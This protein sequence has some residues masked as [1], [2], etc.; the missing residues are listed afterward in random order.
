MKDI[1]KRLSQ[2]NIGKSLAGVAIALLSLSAGA[3]STNPGTYN[4]IVIEDE[5]F[6]GV[7]Q[8]GQHEQAINGLTKRGAVNSRNFTVNNNLCVAYL[9]SGKFNDAKGYC[10]QA[11]A[12]QLKGF[13][14][15]YGVYSRYQDKAIAYTNRGVFRALTGD[16]EGARSD[17]KE[18]VEA[19]SG[20]DQ[21]TINLAK[22]EFSVL[23]RTSILS[24]Q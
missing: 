10:D 17:L 3:E 16:F 22:F 24:Q 1:G 19:D 15:K 18:A 13:R 8:A 12:I 23:D 20:L 5:A 21:P 7:I 11:V 6:G 9:M 14:S 2:I 4:V